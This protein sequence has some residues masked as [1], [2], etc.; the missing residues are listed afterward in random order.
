MNY[1]D[2]SKD[3]ARDLK[4][5]RVAGKNMHT[6]GKLVYVGVKGDSGSPSLEAGNLSLNPYDIAVGF[7]RGQDSDEAHA[8][9]DR[10]VARLEKHWPL[11]TLPSDSGAFPNPECT[12][13]TA[14]PPN[15]SI[16]RGQ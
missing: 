2:G 14:A 13:G 7:A 16:K 12:Q 15:S 1:I 5:L 10:V 4:A 11:R 3:T 8:F 9:S 6:D